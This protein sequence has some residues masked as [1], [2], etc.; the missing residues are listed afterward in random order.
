MIYGLKKIVTYALGTD[1]AG[2]SLAVRPDDTFLA[3]YP[4]SG[5]TWTRFLIANLIHPSQT[6]SFANIERLIPDCE[7]HSSRYM[8]RIPGPRV[9]KSHEYFDHRYRKVIYIV[10]DPRDVALSYYNFQRKSRYIRDDY[11][12]AQYVSSFVDGRVGSADWGTWGEHVGSWLVRDGRPGFLLLRY[13]D[14]VLDPAR[15]L[16]KIAMFFALDPAPQ[17]IANAI[18]RSSAQRMREM[19][20][21][22]ASA[23][24]G[25][26]DK[27][28]D[29]PFV[30]TAASGGWKARLPSE[31]VA[32]I[33]SAWGQLMTRLGYDVSTCPVGEFPV[34]ATAT[35]N[36]AWRV[37]KPDTALS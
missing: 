32:E 21:S 19:E 2:R 27:R 29:I 7:A 9:I 10:R 13:E 15:E 12:L 34:P 31:S 8:K 25:T 33:E 23:W 3:S 30:G 26:K 17:L 16:A 35:E 11:P 14:M 37:R 20:R 22:Q 6:V 18:E 4:R 36:P 5:N 24:V 28:Q 1:I